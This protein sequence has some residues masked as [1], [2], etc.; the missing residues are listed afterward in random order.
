MGVNCVTPHLPVAAC[1]MPG[2][3]TCVS[4]PATD[5]L[6]AQR[7]N[8]VVKSLSQ[9]GDG[10]VYEL[11]PEQNAITTYSPT[12]LQTVFLMR[13]P[14]PGFNLPSGSVADALMQN[15]MA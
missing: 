8:N 14:T 10:V 9:R 11:L 1:T 2:P 7:A 12:I 15:H 4:H 5:I 3:I 6:A 13:D